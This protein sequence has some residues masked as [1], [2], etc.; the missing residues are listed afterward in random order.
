MKGKPIIIGCGGIIALFG[1][2]IIAFF[3]WVA[4]GPEGGVRLPNEME[5]Y[6]LESI[7]RYE[8]G[9]NEELLA[10]YD[11]TISLNGEIA[12]IVTNQRVIYH[13]QGSN[14]SIPLKDIVDV[15]HRYESFIGDIFEVTARTGKM[16]KIEVAPL[17]QG[18]TFKNVLMRAW[19]SAKGDAAN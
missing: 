16:M 9:T 18:K 12:A 7:D 19:D 1:L 11:L 10:Y 5:P 3:V 17:N 6:A 13:N 2:T 8:I 14:S 15:Q 4:M